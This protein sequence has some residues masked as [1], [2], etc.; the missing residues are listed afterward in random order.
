MKSL[1]PDFKLLALR[2]FLAVLF[3]A[4]LVKV[5]IPTRKLFATAVLA[6][7]LIAVAYVFDALKR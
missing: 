6:V 4:I 3:S 1:K 2:F 5:F 7:M